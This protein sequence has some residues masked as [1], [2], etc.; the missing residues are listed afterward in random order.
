MAKKRC[1]GKALAERR[2]RTFQ[3][4]LAE[5]SQ[6]EIADKVGVHAYVVCRNLQTFRDS[7][8]P[9]EP[10]DVQEAY[11]IQM[12][13]MIFNPEP[14]QFD[15]RHPPLAGAFSAEEVAE[16]WKKGGSTTRGSTATAPN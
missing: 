10:P 3:L 8:C 5:F 9:G 2:R 15:P 7:I 12:A 1:T 11:Y 6:E 4:Y 14:G 16:S 13:N